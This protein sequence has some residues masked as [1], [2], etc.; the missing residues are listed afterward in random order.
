MKRVLITLILMISFLWGNAQINDDYGIVFN[1]KVYQFGSVKEGSNS[2]CVFSFVNKSKTPVV[3]NNVRSF[4][5]CIEMTWTKE[6]VKP[7][8]AG[9]IKV[10]FHANTNGTFSK[11][12]N[13]FT[14][15]NSQPI[16]LTIKGSVSS[17]STKNLK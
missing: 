13:V 15:K 14:N 11:T 17:M 7:D 5:G 6:P 9:M 1:T 10:K 4:C 8:D 16:G 2:E 3:I 12:I